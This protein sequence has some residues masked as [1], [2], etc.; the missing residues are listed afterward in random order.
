MKKKWGIGV[1]IILGCIVFGWVTTIAWKHVERNRVIQK[2][3][4]LLQ[5]EADRI[6]L[7]N[8]TLS[9]KIRYFDSEEF[10]EQEAKEKLGLKKEEETV[11][12]IKQFAEEGI[13]DKRETIPIPHEDVD[14]AGIFS[15]PLKWWKMFFQ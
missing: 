12:A 13:I 11:V 2:E 1:V 6:R 3:I 10:R 9:E 7:E 15:H 5:T 4:A 14:E 8:E